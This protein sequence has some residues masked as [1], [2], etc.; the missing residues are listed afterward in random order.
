MSPVVIG[1]ILLDMLPEYPAARIHQIQC[2]LEFDHGIVRTRRSVER[3]LV[4][5]EAVGLA[6]RRRG[7]RKGVSFWGRAERKGAACEPA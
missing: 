6:R 5:L 7:K 1:A 4:A 3:Y 2:R